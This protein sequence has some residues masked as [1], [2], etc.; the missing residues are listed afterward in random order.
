MQFHVIE[1]EKLINR[2]GFRRE[3][4]RP[5]DLRTVELKEFPPRVRA[6]ALPPKLTELMSEAIVQG[7]MPMPSVTKEEEFE[8]VDVT[9]IVQAT[10]R[11]R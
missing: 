9:V 11:Q 5:L 1:R 7:S 4:D 3:E 8:L 2:E 6:I 10:Y